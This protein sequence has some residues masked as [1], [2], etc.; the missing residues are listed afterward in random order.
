MDKAALSRGKDAIDAETAQIIPLVKRAVIFRPWTTKSLRKCP[1]KTINII[2]AQ[3]RTFDMEMTN[4]KQSFLK[5][6]DQV[7][8]AEPDAFYWPNYVWSWN[9]RL[10]KEV[11][12][13]N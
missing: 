7:Q 9:D 10:S 8:F 4:M 6:F 11:I 2:S 1:C 5:K 3:E 13:S 12:S